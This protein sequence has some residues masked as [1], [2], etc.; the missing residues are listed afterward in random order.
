MKKH[1]SW[2]RPKAYVRATR[3][4]ITRV[5]G[6][7]YY[8]R[9]RHPP[10]APA[11]SAHPLVDG[12]LPGAPGAQ[13]ATMSEPTPHRGRWRLIGW[14][15]LLVV[16]LLLVL[17]VV[18]MRSSRL[19]AAFFSA[20]ASKMQFRVEPGAAPASSVRYPQ[21]SPY[22][23][24]V[25]YSAIPDFLTR[26]QARGFSIESQA[27]MNADMTGVVD[28]GLFAPY[29]EKTQV[30][31]TILDCRKDT[32]F[33]ARYPER[34]Y[35]S[36]EAVPTVLVRSLL[37]IE[38]RELLDAD[39]PQRNPAV[40][41]DRLAKAVLDKALTGFSD[42]HRSAGGSTLATQI[43]K[44]RH[45][46]EG[47]TASIQD[48]LRQ[49]VSASVRAYLGGEDTMAA[50]RQLVLDYLNT[51]P[52]A[53]RRGFGEVNGVGDGLWAWYGRDFSEVN[54]LLRAEALNDAPTSA[55]ALAFKQALSLLIAQRRPSYYLADSA[56]DLEQ[57]TDS[58]LRLLASEG[59]ISAALRD[60]A[61]A[62]K[63]D[64]A[65]QVQPVPQ[66]TAFVARKASTAVRTQLA[67]LLGTQR[68]YSLD[69]LDLDVIS[70][71]DAQTQGDVT[72][73]LRALRE[74]DVA[75]A[76]ALHGKGL[77]GN[78]DPA[79]VVY[80]FTLLE[81][82]DSANY[83]RVQ[84]DNYE[85]P[86]DIN[87]GAKLDLGS[88]AKLRTLV[89]YL[90]IVANLHQR[91]H[92]LTAEEL[93][94]TAVDPKDK[95]TQWALDYLARHPE[96]DL[97]AM[98]EAA[99][100]RPYSASPAERFFTGGGLH[101][102]NNFKREDNGRVMSV[103]EG[104]R[105]SV[106]L[107]FVRLLRDVVHHYMFLTPGS[108]AGLLKDADDPRRASYLSRFADRE[109]RE[110]IYR[111]LPKYQGKT[112]Q[113]A[114]QLLMQGVRPTPVRLAAIFRTIAPTASQD[115]FASFLQEYLPN[116]HAP[117]PARLAQLYAQYA[118]DAMSL[119]DR[120]YV[121]TVH[122]LELWVIGYLRSHPQASAA[123]VIAAS[124]A[125]RQQVYQWLFSTSRK[126]AQD[127][128]ILSLLEVEGFLEIHRQWKRM[129]YPFDSLVPSYATAL[130][131]SADRPAALAELMGILVNGGVRKPTQRIQ[132][133]R[134]APATP[135][136]ASLQRESGKS[137]QVLAPQVAQVALRAIQDVVD[138]GTA[139]RV[140]NAFVGA[141][142]HVF[143]V[144]GK[145][146][147]GDHRFDVYGAGGQLLE[148]R[149]V[150][151]S[152]TFVFNIGQRFFGS[153]TAYVHGPQAAKYDFTSALPVQL[154]KLLAPTLT[155]LLDTPPT[156]TGS[157]GQCE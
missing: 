84:S 98:L 129:G 57:L 141:D 29:R 13:A 23:E 58:H 80:S 115:A 123:Q 107:V 116:S 147:T 7:T 96:A 139:R 65:S 37:F 118:P 74:D 119:A 52:L 51:V 90:D 12:A 83:L 36:F 62:V 11:H 69:R 25:G 152:A 93:R 17:A 41:W 35:R 100:E 24:R 43:E 86:L 22:D 16:V 112:A 38:N 101:S 117:E 105:H 126:Q 94:K 42:D 87:D 133:L 131:A 137:E 149:V 47:R 75:K 6:A 60:A 4:L 154:L 113:E 151:R 32:L 28:S 103:R 138:E 1:A 49:M 66:N 150:N 99:L 81:R 120:G 45:S 68:L 39:N 155:P 53:A 18:E 8:P 46:A 104:L 33:A 34:V 157:S 77:L 61:L 26:L 64:R 73:L 122:P 106:N 128:R 145:T 82:G 148:S 102:F 54:P 110:F 156:G 5:A 19:Q 79:N 56:S 130:G 71:L 76:S 88:T 59:V 135:Y 70:T 111:F 85:Q 91:L 48:K 78:G 125:E 72:R 15:L 44:Y 153:I 140:K 97:T 40:E 63:L 21:D 108:S 132:G 127:T 50:R 9:R 10:T 114:E 92:A 30:G 89:S 134:F 142:G 31:L 55:S 67:G 20:L 144:G 2:R 124:Q 95:I 146:G 14:L 109:G 136:E 27:R 143:A 3:K 121:A